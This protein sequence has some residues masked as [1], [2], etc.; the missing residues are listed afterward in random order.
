MNKISNFS[1]FE[2]WTK[3]RIR[4]FFES[5]QFW[6]RPI[7]ETEQNSK[8]NNFWI[9]TKLESE[10]NFIFVQ[11]W[12]RKKIQNLYKKRN[13]K[14]PAKTNKTIKIN[15]PT[16]TAKTRKEKKK[17]L[18]MGPFVRALRACSIAARYEREI[19]LRS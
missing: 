17:L 18:L 2:I 16:W 5:A 10:Q 7:F 3:Y 19:G 12:I 6:T 15:K 1:K 9:Q 4:T 14:N 13:I 11:F 8:L